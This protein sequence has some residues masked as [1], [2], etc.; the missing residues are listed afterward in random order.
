M[1]CELVVC[2]ELT[3]F[4]STGGLVLL[5][6]KNEPQKIGGYFAEPFKILQKLECILS[7]ERYFLKWSSFRGRGVES[8]RGHEPHFC[9]KTRPLSRE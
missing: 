4:P 1:G 9:K 5:D 3:A 6:V 2:F 8:K 7:I